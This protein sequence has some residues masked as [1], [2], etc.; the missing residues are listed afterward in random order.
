MLLNLLEMT[1]KKKKNSLVKIELTDGER[2]KE[3][4]DVTTI[5]KSHN[6]IEAPTFA[7]I[8]VTDTRGPKDH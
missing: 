5:D 4:T 3:K 1:M 8:G 7:G 2:K 6:Q